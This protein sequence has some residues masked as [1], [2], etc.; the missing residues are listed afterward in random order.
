MSLENDNLRRLVLITIKGRQI[1]LGSFDSEI[2]A[3]IAYDQAAV[4]YFGEFACLNSP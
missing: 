2:E 4:K 1:H 3:A